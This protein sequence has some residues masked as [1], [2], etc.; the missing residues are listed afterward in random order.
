MNEVKIGKTHSLCY[1]TFEENKLTSQSTYENLNY[2]SGVY[3]F[4]FRKNPAYF[5]GENNI[6]PDSQFLFVPIPKGIKDESRRENIEVLIRECEGIENLIE[7]LQ[8]E[9]RGKGH[10][11]VV[12]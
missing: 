4:N 1:R 9:L 6:I 7:F 8:K 3:R 2:L 5:A 10:E 11:L 12:P